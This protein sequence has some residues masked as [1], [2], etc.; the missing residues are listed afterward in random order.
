MVHYAGYPAGTDAIMEIARKHDIKIIEDASDAHGALYKGR[1]VSTLGNVS[2][3]FLMSGKSFGTGEDGILLTN[4]REI[5]ER[6]LISGH[7]SRIADT[8]R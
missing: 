8:M 3:F 4:D 7:Y 6:A 1:M 2:A 5:Y